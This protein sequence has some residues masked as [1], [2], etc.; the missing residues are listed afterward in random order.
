M[1]R[2]FIIDNARY[3]IR[4]YHFDG[5]RLD[6]TH[7]LIE[8]DAGAIVRE[9]AA[10][11]ADAPRPAGVHPRRGSSQPRGDDRGSGRRRLGARRRLG[12]RLPPRHA[13]ACSPATSTA[14]YADYRGND[15]GARAHDPPGLA[16]HR[17]AVARTWARTAARI[18]R[19]SRCDRFVVCLQNHD[20]I[21]NRALGDRLHAAISP[22]AWRAASVVLLTA[23]MTPLLFMG[24]EWAAEHAV[25]V[26]HRSRARARAARDRRPPPRVRELPGVLERGGAR[27]DS[28]SAVACDATRTAAWT[29]TN[30]RAGARR[31]ARALSRAAGAAAR[32]ARARRAATCTSGDADAPDDGSIVIRRAK[33]GDG[34]LDRRAT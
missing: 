13:P 3:W 22:E 8:D 25:P 18:R 33:I 9:I 17:A 5:L 21:G 26:L 7:A 27:S 15:R 16:V 14:Y 24:Q 29:G 31:G 23:P 28:R 2:R 19:A 30:A 6:A 12:R 1:V 10:G 34:V 20:Q 11:G 32:S 4:E